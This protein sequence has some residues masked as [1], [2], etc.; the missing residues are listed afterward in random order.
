ME[1]FC[2]LAK[3]KAGGPV[4]LAKAIGGVSPQA[5]SQW[6]RVPVGRVLEL[7]RIVG[8]SRHHLRPDIFGAPP[9]EEDEC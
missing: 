4:A 9:M 3:Q 6:K 8:I 2:K 1:H 7:E 5:V